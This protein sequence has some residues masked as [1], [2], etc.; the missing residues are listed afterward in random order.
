MAR[1]NY[2][3]NRKPSDERSKPM[4]IVDVYTP[5]NPWHGPMYY[6]YG[7]PVGAEFITEWIDCGDGY[8]QPF[9]F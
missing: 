1:S 4:I 3:D 7:I 6:A 2:R 5:Q 9:P 8:Y